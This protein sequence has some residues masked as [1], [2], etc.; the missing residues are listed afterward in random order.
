[1]HACLAW[2]FNPFLICRPCM[3]NI[4]RT[5]HIDILEGIQ[6]CMRILYT[7]YK[8]HY[9]DSCTIYNTCIHISCFNDLHSPFLRFQHLH[10]RPYKFM[11]QCLYVRITNVYVNNCTGTH[12]IDRVY[13][14]LVNFINRLPARLIIRNCAPLKIFS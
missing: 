12:T 3:Q 9:K 1:M 13:T 2:W 11:Y 10:D 7:R 6:C 5:V 14:H 4:Y 8:M